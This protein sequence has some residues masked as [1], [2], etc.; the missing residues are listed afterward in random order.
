[1][2]FDYQRNL[3]PLKGVYVKRVVRKNMKLPRHTQ[4][5]GIP[6]GDTIDSVLY[7]SDGHCIVPD[8]IVI[9]VVEIPQIKRD[10]VLY[11]LLHGSLHQCRHPKPPTLEEG[12]DGGWD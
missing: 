1:M 3:P 11:R 10:I 12:F 2:D 8:K 6:P 7:V 5:I 4:Y 9:G